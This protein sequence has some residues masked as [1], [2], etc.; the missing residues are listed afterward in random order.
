MQRTWTKYAHFRCVVRASEWYSSF[1]LGELRWATVTWGISAHNFI[2]NSAIRHAWWGW[3]WVWGCVVQ[4]VRS[5]AKGN[6]RKLLVVIALVAAQ[7]FLVPPGIIFAWCRCCRQHRT[8]PYILVCMWTRGTSSYAGNLWRAVWWGGRRGM[9]AKICTSTSI[10]TK[11]HMK[12]F[13]A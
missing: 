6:D 8:Y 5:E 1:C 12:W 13:Q 9:P 3:A 10:C 4:G 11:L 2:N 7:I